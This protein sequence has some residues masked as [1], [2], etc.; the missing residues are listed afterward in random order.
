MSLPFNDKFASLN[1]QCQHNQTPFPT[2]QRFPF[3]LRFSTLFI[4]LLHLSSFICL[5][6]L[7]PNPVY[8]PPSSLKFSMRDLSGISSSCQSQS[9][10]DL[11]EADLGCIQVGWS[12]G[13]LVGF[14]II[15]SAFA[16]LPLLSIFQMGRQSDFGPYQTHFFQWCPFAEV[17]SKHYGILLNAW[18]TARLQELP[19]RYK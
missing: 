17:A 11:S 16:S 1:C 5:F 7:L 6:P 13:W 8:P 2:Y 12:V 15:F 10:S 4:L 14:P 18:L 3:S 9:Q 19:K